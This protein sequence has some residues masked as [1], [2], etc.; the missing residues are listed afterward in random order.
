M[1]RFKKPSTATYSAPATT[2]A[3]TTITWTANEP[4]PSTT[5]TI[6]DGDVPTVAELGQSVANLTDQ[7]NKLVADN[8]AMKAALAQVGVDDADLRV[9]LQEPN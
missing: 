7:V 9:V 4:T 2:A 6:A 3:T 1:F 5:Q 8:V